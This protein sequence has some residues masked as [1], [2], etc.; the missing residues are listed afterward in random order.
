MVASNC[1]WKHHLQTQRSD[2]NYAREY[3]NNCMGCNQ[4]FSIKHSIMITIIILTTKTQWNRQN[5]HE[6]KDMNGIEMKFS[7]YD[8]RLRN[9]KYMFLNFSFGSYSSTGFRLFV[10]KSLMESGLLNS[11]CNKYFLSSKRKNRLTN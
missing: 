9:I 4:L 10:Y 8:V 6:C 3:I 11:F 2:Q 1:E 5:F 7:V